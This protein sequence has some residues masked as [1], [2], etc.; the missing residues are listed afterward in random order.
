MTD[1]RR[2]VEDL[3]QEIA[4][5][6]VTLRTSLEKRAKLSRKIGELRKDVPSVVAVP[7][8]HHIDRLMEG[9][10]G[11]VPPAALR[12]IFREII[13]TCFSLEQPVVV[14]YSGVEGAF[15]HAAARSRFGVA[16]TFTPCETVA[17]ALD[18]ITRNRASYAV[19]PYETRTDGLMQSTIAAL[20][21]SD[22]KIVVCFE[23]VISLQLASKAGSLAEIEKIYATSK[24]HAHCEH[25]LA[26]ELPGAQI[27]DVKTPMAAC[28]LAAADPRSAVLAHESIAAEHGLEVLRRNVRDEGEERVRYAIVGPRPSSRSG[29]DLTAIVFAVNDS[30]G[31]LHEVLHQFAERGVNMTKIQSRPAQGEAW[32]YLF[33]IEV[34][35]HATD[36][37]L[38][39]A[40][41]ELRRHAR[42]F[43][44]LGSYQ[45][46]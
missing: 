1:K 14:A 43:K 20:T 38:V 35:G 15:V 41:E 3:R 17:S 32:Q 42:F 12:E 2:E 34:Q 13:A 39:G 5:L 31:A 6:D 28:Q 23:T 36:R 8:R 19:V 37:Q 9:A 30:P 11:D 25:F 4:K 26:Q 45:S 46:S 7:D 18:E 33:F 22:L 16:A 10:T 24:D 29:N 44:V 21:A 40:I 27:V